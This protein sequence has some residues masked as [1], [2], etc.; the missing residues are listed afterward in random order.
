MHEMSVHMMMV[1]Q[2]NNDAPTDAPKEMTKGG[3]GNSGGQW[4][5]QVTKKVA[6]QIS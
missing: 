6:A 3:S 4:N 2:T 5:I 1:Q